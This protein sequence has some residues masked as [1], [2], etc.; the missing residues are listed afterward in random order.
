[1]KSDAFSIVSLGCARS[2]VDS[3]GMV[4]DLTSVGFDLVPEG[5]REA[6]TVLNT[7]SFIQAAIDETEDNIRL[8]LGI[9]NGA[10]F[11]TSQWWGAIRVDT[12][13]P[14]SLKNSQV[15][16]WLSTSESA[17]LKARSVSLYLNVN[18]YQTL[19]FQTHMGS[20]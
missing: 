11:N 16:M 4:N 13:A 7:C 2:L 14:S 12:N 19:D 8:L 20:Y 15:W 6:I 18:L 9:K 17:Q 1:M 3:E 10:T 5:T